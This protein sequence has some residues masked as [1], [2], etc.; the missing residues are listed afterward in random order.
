M[1]A[2]L[3]HRRWTSA[4]PQSRQSVRQHFQAESRFLRI[5]GLPAFVS[6]PE[7]TTAPSAEEILLWVRRF[8]IFEELR[9]AILAFRQTYS[10]SWIIE[11]HDYRTTA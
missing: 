10:K 3:G 6:E 9:L 1:A 11:R 4:P 5:K 8:H 2:S 7:G